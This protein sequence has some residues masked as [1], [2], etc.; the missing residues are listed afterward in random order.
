[1]NQEPAPG[2]AGHLTFT[3]AGRHHALPLAA[4]QEVLRLPLLQPTEGM[5]SHIAGLFN[6]RGQVVAVQNL[7]GRLGL[8]VGAPRAE[9]HLIVMRGG[10]SALWVEEIEGVV[11]LGSLQQP[12]E[13]GQTA[14]DLAAVGTQLYHLLNL[15]QL[16]EEGIEPFN[17][18]LLNGVL[19]SERP[20]LEAR[21]EAYLETPPREITTLRALLS[22]E[23]N[24]EGFAVDLTE[25]RE[26]APCP[27]IHPLPGAPAAYLGLA[28]HRGEPLLVMDLRPLIGLPQSPPAPGA[29]LLVVDEAGGHLGL[30][31]DAVREVL[32]LDS[33]ELQPPILEHGPWEWV[34]GEWVV[35]GRPLSLLRLRALLAQS[36]S[37][38]SFA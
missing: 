25:I 24:G 21:S 12:R 20:L 38:S 37:A 18:D 5:P 6:L 27:A 30:Y 16:M 32:S 8:P 36:D 14:P 23:L 3:V 31:T 9:D 2:L 13:P 34:E 29:Q 26:I 22:F 17:G 15:D 1:M 4:V 28:S 11:E 19:P 33:R 35:D 7:A 10:R